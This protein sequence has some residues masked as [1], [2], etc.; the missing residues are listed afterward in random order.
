VIDFGGIND[1]G[2]FL[3]TLKE[4][5]G[6][7][8]AST[9]LIARDA[10]TNPDGAVQS[11][12]TAL[13]KNGFAVPERPFAFAEGPPRVA[14]LV[15]PGFD[16]SSEGDLL[17]Q[18]TLEDLCLSMTE[19]DSVH[20]CVG[21]YVDCLE[22][23]GVTLTQPHKTRL[24]AYLAGKN[25]LVGLKIGEAARVGAWDW[26]HSKINPFREIIKAM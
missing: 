13:K 20:E 5:P 25:D 9:F 21:I 6:Y 16:L 1:L 7:E 17:M 12:K 24:H 8:K 26:N 4:I 23:K 3:K 11:I 22:S 14:Y 18:G 19:S 10:E 15:F 2:E